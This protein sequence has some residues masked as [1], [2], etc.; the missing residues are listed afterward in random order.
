[1]TARSPIAAIAA[2]L[3]AEAARLTNDAADELRRLDVQ[4]RRLID[5]LEARDRRPQPEGGSR[6]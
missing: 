4:N 2:R 5:R 6:D 3:T 1:M